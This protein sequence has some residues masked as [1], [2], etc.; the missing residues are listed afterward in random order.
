MTA[1][2]ETKSA[3][4][5]RSKVVNVYIWHTSGPKSVVANVFLWMVIQAPALIDEKLVPTNWGS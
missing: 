2:D 3:S 4:E 1:R 5:A